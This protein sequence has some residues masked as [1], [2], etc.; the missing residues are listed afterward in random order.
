MDKRH[1]INVTLLLSALACT[2]LSAT[3]QIEVSG[4]IQYER[5][6]LIKSIAL[7]LHQ[8][9]LDKEAAVKISGEL[10]GEDALRFSL[11]AENLM[12]H[13][14]E[15]NGGE[16]IEY[17]SQEALYRQK[18]ELHSYGYLVGMVTKI[19]QRSPDEKVLQQLS[20]IAKVNQ[21]I[22]KNV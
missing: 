6:N 20:N 8:K 5:K 15:L 16:V 12:A 14:S 18:V 3:E 4:S 2:P 1:L 9:G 17:F 7:H 10:A 11:M 21:S 13:C 19:K 22:L